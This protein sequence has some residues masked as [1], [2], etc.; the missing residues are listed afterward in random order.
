VLIECPLTSNSSFCSVHLQ[1]QDDTAII[2]GK[3][4]YIPAT[5]GNS[6][7]T[8]TPLE[9]SAS[10]VPGTAVGNATGIVTQPGVAD[11][12]RFNA[13]AG[14]AFVSGQVIPRDNLSLMAPGVH[15]YSQILWWCVTLV[16]LYAS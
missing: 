14:R 16:R 3:L 12:F 13:T 15:A 1:L 6:R 8:A 5:N 9:L 10:G 7:A 2:A 11:F 4:S